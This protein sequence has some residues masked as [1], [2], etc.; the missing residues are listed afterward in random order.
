M[1]AAGR[2]TNA[3]FPVGA[4]IRTDVPL[5][6]R[7][8]CLGIETHLPLAASIQTSVQTHTY[9]YT[10]FPDFHKT[11]GGVCDHSRNMEHTQTCLGSSIDH[12]RFA[13]HDTDIHTDRHTHRQE[14]TD[15]Y[16]QYVGIG[17]SSMPVSH[18]GN[19]SSSFYK[20]LTHT[21]QS[22]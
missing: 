20:S 21:P 14:H 7:L 9:M 1:G 17:L 18:F 12:E 2:A 3:D 5:P 10:H 22:P 11:A 15:A 6:W 16:I 8:L 4:K 13:Q 19:H